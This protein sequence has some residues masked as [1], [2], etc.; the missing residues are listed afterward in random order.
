[1]Q[2]KQ[3][4][5]YRESILCAE[6]AGASLLAMVVNDNACFLVTR[7][8]LAFIASELAPTGICGSTK[9]SVPCLQRLWC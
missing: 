8:A 9:R 3:L 1:M 4:L 5:T 2:Y 6:L 7:A